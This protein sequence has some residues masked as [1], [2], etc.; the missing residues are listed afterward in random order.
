MSMKINPGQLPK[1]AACEALLHAK[2]THQ[3]NIPKE[4]I[5]KSKIDI[6]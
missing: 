1:G 3:Y 2:E 6:K 4:G 5:K